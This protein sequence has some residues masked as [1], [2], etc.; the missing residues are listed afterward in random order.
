MRKASTIIPLKG[1]I[2]I[3]YDV[4]EEDGIQITNNIGLYMQVD[5]CNAIVL[6]EDIGFAIRTALNAQMERFIQ[7]EEDE[8]DRQARLEGWDQISREG[9]Y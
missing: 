1:E 3:F 2:E 9:G 8:L 4:C 5:E 7:A 6:D